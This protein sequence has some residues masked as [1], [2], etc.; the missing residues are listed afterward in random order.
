MGVA[1][2]SEAKN[3]EIHANQ[4][5]LLMGVADKSEAKKQKFTQ[6]K[7][8]YLWGQQTKVRQKLI[9]VAEKSEAKIKSVY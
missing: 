9:Q 3:P 4:T 5:C 6:I 2:K 1:D 7:P 8:V